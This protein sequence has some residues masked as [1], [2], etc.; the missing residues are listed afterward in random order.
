[1]K[2]ASLPVYVYIIGL[3]EVP[4]CNVTQKLLHFTFWVVHV[5]CTYELCLLY[6]LTKDS[7]RVQNSKYELKICR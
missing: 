5:L 3:E 2:M 1:M 4:I 6:K 7:K